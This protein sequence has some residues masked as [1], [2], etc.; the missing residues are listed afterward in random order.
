MYGSDC[1]GY[2]SVA[3]NITRHTTSGLHNDNSFPQVRNTSEFN[4]NDRLARLSPGDI[5]NFSGTHTM[6]VERI[7]PL[8][9]GNFLI[10]TLEQTPHVS[11]SL[12]WQTSQ[13][14]NYLGRVAR[15][16]LAQDYSW[17]WQ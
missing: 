10:D 5:L 13:L 7:T 8:S 3:F 17:R 12:T 6:I 14:A 1:S 11:R 2:V 9:N 16:A 15:P 4:T